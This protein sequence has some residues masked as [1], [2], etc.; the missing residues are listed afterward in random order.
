MANETES[1]AEMERIGPFRVDGTEY[2]GI[3]HISGLKF[4]RLMWNRP[5]PGAEGDEG[6]LAEAVVSLKNR[7]LRSQSP[8]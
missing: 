1:A 8:N 5:P 7:F 3:K 4:R 6:A 2:H